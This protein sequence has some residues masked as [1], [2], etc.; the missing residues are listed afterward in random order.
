MNKIV[1][2]SG[3]T[4][5]HCKMKV[6]QRLA[7]LKEVKSVEVDLLEGTAEIELSETISDEKLAEVIK[8]A[9]YTLSSVEA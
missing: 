2:I 3:M 6:E 5:G 8:D 9:G 7:E 4:C 1:H